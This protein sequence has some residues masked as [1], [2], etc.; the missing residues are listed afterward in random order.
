MQ[1]K[2]TPIYHP[3]II[4]SHVSKKNNKIAEKNLFL[5]LKDLIFF[6]FLTK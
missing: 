6:F 3:E 1:G 2:N 4:S 5:F